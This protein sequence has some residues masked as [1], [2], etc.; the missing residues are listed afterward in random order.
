MKKKKLILLA[1]L[2]LL[3]GNIQAQMTGGRGDGP[4]NEVAVSTGDYRPGGF[5]WKLGYNK[6]VGK[7]GNSLNTNYSLPE[8]VRHYGQGANH[9]VGM[10]FGGFRYFT[11]MEIPKSMLG[12]EISYDMMFNFSTGSNDG[13][14]GNTSLGVGPL[15]TF[16]ATDNLYLNLSYNLGFGFY[17]SY[18]YMERYLMLYGF[19]DYYGE[20]MFYKGIG[21]MNKINFNVQAKSFIVGFDINMAK[22]KSRSTNYEADHFN[23][24]SNG[25]Y[26]PSDFALTANQTVFRV[27]IGTKAFKSK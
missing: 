13:L 18:V 23:A 5:I 10:S 22:F 14:Y 12:I 11:K 21:V 24:L 3:L 26:G 1:F 16:R 9:G 4:T 15:Y 8:N 6:P 17:A 27:Y 7:F 25:D 19:S 2:Y 20:D